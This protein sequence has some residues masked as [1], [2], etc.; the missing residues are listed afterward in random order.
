MKN[1]TGETIKGA[2]KEVNMEQIVRDVQI[3]VQI[4]QM[5]AAEAQEEALNLEMELLSAQAAHEKKEE[6]ERK[7]RETNEKVAELTG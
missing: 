7:G 5:E 1:I 6:A 2:T 3:K 4:E